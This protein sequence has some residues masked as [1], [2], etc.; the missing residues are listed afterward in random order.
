MKNKSLFGAAIVGRNLGSQWRN[1][2]LRLVRESTA[3]EMLARGGTE[4]ETMKNRERIKRDRG[5]RLGMAH[6]KQCGWKDR[7]PPTAAQLTQ[8]KRPAVKCPTCGAG[9]FWSKL[10]KAQ[11]DLL[12]P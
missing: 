2:I 1:A 8:S 12:A 10:T 7:L 11:A 6:C 4:T 3:M 5:M 9:I